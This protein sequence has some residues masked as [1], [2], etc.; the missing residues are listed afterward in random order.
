MEKVMAKRKTK[1]IFTSVAAA[2]SA[3]MMV[4]L[5]VNTYAFQPDAPALVFQKK[6]A[7]KWAAD[8]KKVDQRLAALR[9]RF[10]KRPNIIYVLAD[11]VGWGELGA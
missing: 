4:V 2:L 8:D 9:K 1:A 7:A 10:G 5:P 11:D 6:N 3:T